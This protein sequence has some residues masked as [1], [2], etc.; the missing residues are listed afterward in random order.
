MIDWLSE[1]AEKKEKIMKV[2]LTDHEE[3]RHGDKSGVDS[4]KDKEL[5]LF[6]FIFFH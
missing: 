1:G 2:R 4:Q 5:Q 6:K 3:N